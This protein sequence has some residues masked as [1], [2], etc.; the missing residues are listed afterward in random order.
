M[1]RALVI[2]ASGGIGTAISAELSNKG[3]D[4]TGLSRSGDG[5]DVTEEASVEAAFARLE[6]SFDVIF[7]ATG[8]LEPGGNA[9]EKAVRE[10]SVEAMEAAFRVNAI[11]PML[12]LKHSLR[13]LPKT[14]PS[15]FAALSARVGS[16]GDNGIG[17]W[18]SYRASKTA[19]NQ[20]IHGAAIE[21]KRT[22]KQAT[23]VCLHPGTV[24]TDFTAKYAGRHKTV[25]ATQA[26]ANLVRVI[27]GLGPAQSGQFYDYAG[28]EIPW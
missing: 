25:P 15:V 10:V 1:K 8:A 28:Q 23:V 7:V 14:S 20:F 12:V 11:G 27:E 21:L 16:I 24:E 4:V 3:Y 9:P 18:H 6:G 5:L 2:G 19:L 17:G 22:H 26:A 13:L